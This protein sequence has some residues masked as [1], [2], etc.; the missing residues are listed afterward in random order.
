VSGDPGARRRLFGLTAHDDA[1]QTTIGA[2]HSRLVMAL[3]ELSTAP[4][5][6]REVRRFYDAA[7]LAT[8]AVLASSG[9][10]AATLPRVTRGGVTV[11]SGPNDLWSGVAAFQLGGPGIRLQGAS[12]AL[13]LEPATGTSK[14][15]VEITCPTGTPDKV[16]GF[17]GSGYYYDTNAAVVYGNVFDPATT[18]CPSL[19]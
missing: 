17:V 13:N 3:P 2:F 12:G 16:T 4:V 1:D 10:V 19:K 8:Y 5:G 11:A 9:A 7:Y 14:H 6:A 18:Q 15:D